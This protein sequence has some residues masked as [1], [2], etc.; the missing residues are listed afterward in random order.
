MDLISGRVERYIHTQ[1]IFDWTLEKMAG[2][3]QKH[4]HIRIPSLTEPAHTFMT[5]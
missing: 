4:T 3:V 5:N 1:N 2:C